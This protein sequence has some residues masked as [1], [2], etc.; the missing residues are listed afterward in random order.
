MQI[1]A[2]TYNKGLFTSSSIRLKT[3]QAKHAQ[4]EV[5]S[6]EKISTCNL[7]GCVSVGPRRLEILH[8]FFK[9]KSKNMQKKLKNVSKKNKK[10]PGGPYVS[11]SGIPA[12]AVRLNSSSWH[13]VVLS[14]WRKGHGM[15]KHTPL[16]S[17]TKNTT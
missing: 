10:Q 13:L 3:V 7:C 9:H 4:P 14:V 15:L 1:P 11:K 2:N 6:E 8:D 12:I 16:L 5:R 17:H